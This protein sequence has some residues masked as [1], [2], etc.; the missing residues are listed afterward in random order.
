[1]TRNNVLFKIL[2]AIELA[3]LPMVV[4]AYLYLPTWSISLF[5]AGILLAKI[6]LHLFNDK[7]KA[8]TVI[9]AVGNILVFSVLLILFM[10]ANMISVVIGVVALSL[11][12]LANIFKISLYQKALN[13]TIEA[14]DFCYALFEILTI[15]A[16]TVL[17]FYELLANIGLFA[18]ILTGAVAVVY[19]AYYTVKYTDLIAKL[20]KL[21]K[22]N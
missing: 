17:S 11:I 3:L 8:S 19:K 18:I 20:K 22:R 5:V 1:M 2:F 7:T 12:V 16:F 14:V 21:F 13:E 9:I 15:A 4:F 6:W 10:V